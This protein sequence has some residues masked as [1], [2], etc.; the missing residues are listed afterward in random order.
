MERKYITYKMSN[1]GEKTW[2]EHSVSYIS[3]SIIEAGDLI[4]SVLTE[5]RGFESRICLC[6]RISGSV[7]IFLAFVPFRA[8]EF[9]CHQC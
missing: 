3:H 8:N 5:L 2:T 7:L 6:T 9:G 1:D 4:Q